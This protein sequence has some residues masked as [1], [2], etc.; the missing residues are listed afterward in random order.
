M[1]PTDMRR[2]VLYEQLIELLGDERAATLMEH[3]PPGGWDK[4]ATKDDVNT[5]VLLSERRLHS[6]ITDVRGEITELRGEIT[7]LRG[8]IT[9]VRGE[10]TDVRGEITYVRGEITELRGEIKY[11]LARQTRTMVFTML[12]IAIT[13]WLALLLPTVAG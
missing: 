2:L 6:E 11:D 4:V 12:G 1:S 7:E 10:I 8:E 13:I 5:A 3:L 9:D